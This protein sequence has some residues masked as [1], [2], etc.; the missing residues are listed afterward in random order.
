M[1]D[2]LIGFWLMAVV[3]L[4]MVLISSILTRVNGVSILTVNE[5]ESLK[6]QLE[7]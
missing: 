7:D 6:P 4:L 5:I 3:F 2:A 1:N